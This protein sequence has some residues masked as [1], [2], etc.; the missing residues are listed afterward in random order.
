MQVVLL[1]ANILYSRVLRDFTLYSAAEELIDIRWTR[2]ILDEMTQH[3]MSNV[4]SFDLA[5]AGRLTTA[6]NE[7]FP[8]ASIDIEEGVWSRVRSMDLPDEGDCHVIAAAMSAG[9]NITQGVQPDCLESGTVK[10]RVLGVS[11]KQTELVLQYRQ[12]L[13]ARFLLGALPVLEGGK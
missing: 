6:M 7:T 13:D 5:S 3:L 12:P 9:V 2:Q 11:V 10:R 1:D 8:A 4:E